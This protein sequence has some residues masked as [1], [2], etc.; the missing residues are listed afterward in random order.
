MGAVK[1]RG[2]SNTE[3]TLHRHALHRRPLQISFAGVDFSP[4]RSVFEIQLAEQ[5][6]SNE[7]ATD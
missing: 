6:Q 2:R 4:W 7:E 1:R 5:R 3:A